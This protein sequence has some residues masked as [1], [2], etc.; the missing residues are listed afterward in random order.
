M[1]IDCEPRCG[2]CRRAEPPFTKAGAYGTYE[3]A[4]RELIQL[5]KYDGVRPAASALGRMAAEALQTV[6]PMFRDPQP[7]MVPVPLHAR[8]LRQRRFN[9]SELIARAALKSLNGGARFAVAP[10]ILARVRETTSQTGLTRHQRRANV[11]AAFVV[12]RPEAI[13]GRD[14][15]LVDDV[16]TTGT[17][18]AECARVLRRAGAKQV[19]VITV[20]RVLA[21][22]P[23]AIKIDL[24]AV[25]TAQAAHA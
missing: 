14:V 20:A 7:V 3:G 9:Q 25:K 4:L 5:L 12:Q 2:L 11:R 23:P 10:A 13:K 15:V 16:F 1:P 18:V 8:K 22:E 24:N 21:P 19:F 17:T 6:T